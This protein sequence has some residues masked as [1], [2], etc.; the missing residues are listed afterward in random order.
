MSPFNKKG[1]FV[2]RMKTSTFLKKKKRS[3]WQSCTS[4]FP[5]ATVEP[6]NTLTWCL[7]NFVVVEEK[8]RVRRPNFL[9]KKKKEPLFFIFVEQPPR[10]S[11]KPL[12]L[13]SSSISKPSTSKQKV[14]HKTLSSQLFFSEITYSSNKE[15]CLLQQHPKICAKNDN[16]IGDQL[17]LFFTFWIN[18]FFIRITLWQSIEKK[19]LLPCTTRTTKSWHVLQVLFYDFQMKSSFFRFRRP[20]S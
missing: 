19:N 16:L 14:I 11:H 10:F 9:W 17:Q 1:L 4:H 7:I 13:L 2:K 5:R 18:Y 12:E 20:A 8:K 6:E 15:K 3:F